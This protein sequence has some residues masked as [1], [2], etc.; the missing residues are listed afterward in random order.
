LK[1]NS[2]NLTLSKIFS[3]LENFNNKIFIYNKNNFINKI[4]QEKTLERF[5][6]KI[7]SKVVGA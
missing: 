1:K 5:F 4:N 7:K 3:K 2:Q 6:I